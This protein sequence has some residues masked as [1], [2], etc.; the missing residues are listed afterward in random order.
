M[1][2]RVGV[3]RVDTRVDPYDV[4]GG[5]PSA[6][7][8]T[9]PSTSH[10]LRSGTQS[11]RAQGPALRH[12]TRSRKPIGTMF[13][14]SQIALPKNP[15]TMCGRGRKVRGLRGRPF[16]RFPFDK[17]RDRGGGRGIGH[18]EVANTPTMGRKVRGVKCQG[19]SRVQRSERW[20]S[21]LR[22]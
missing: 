20:V 12:P 19:S 5:G 2:K 6:S 4:T 1:P 16:D 22:E 7:S 21:G 3:E 17:L 18:G 8:G 14:R 15:G 11:S 10:S 9:G 13:A